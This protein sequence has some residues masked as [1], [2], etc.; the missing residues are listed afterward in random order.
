MENANGQPPVLDAQQVA[1]LVAQQLQQQLNQL[2][3][4]PVRPTAILQPTFFSGLEAADVSEWVQHF[5]VTA[6]ANRWNDDQKLLRLPAYLTSAAAHWYQQYAHT[7]QQANAALTWNDTLQAMVSYF[8]PA[9]FERRVRLKLRNRKLLTG[10]K[11]EHYFDDVIH[12]AHQA[13]PNMNDT[14]KV[15]YLVEGL[16]SMFPL[17]E[18]VALQNIRTPSEFM[19]AASRT[20][21]VM[22]LTQPVSIAQVVQSNIVG[23]E[24]SSDGINLLSA[25]LQGVCQN[26]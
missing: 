13:D 22:H 17:Y 10:E 2:P 23:D 20:L 16:K 8:R 6:N 3:P 12:L 15:D 5:T 25:A 7:Q 14:K 24:P 9:D 1:V 21:E 26:F 4:H 19:T 18:K 11:I